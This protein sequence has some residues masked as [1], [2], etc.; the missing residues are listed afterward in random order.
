MLRRFVGVLLLLLALA[1]LAPLG[2]RAAS[3]AREATPPVVAA[4]PD[5]RF[6]E[7]GGLRI[8]YRT[9]GP[10]DGPPLLLVHGAMAWSETWRDIAEPLGAAGLR[11]IAL[12][13][14][15][16]GFSERPSDMYF[17]RAAQA[18]II[19][20]FADALRIERFALAGHSFGGGATV[21]AAFTA[22]DRVL[23]LVLLDVA[24]G[25]GRPYSGPPLAGLLASE[26]VRNAAIAMSFTNPLL[27][28]KGLRDFVHDD[29]LVTDERIALYQRPMVVRGTTRAV[30]HWF[31][32]GLFGNE[33]GSRAADLA[34]YRGFDRPVLVIWGREDTVTPLAQGQE[35]AAAFP[36]GRLEVLDG[37]NHIPHVEAPEAVAGLMAR[38]LKAPA[39]TTTTP[40]L[41]GPLTGSLR[42]AIQL[43]D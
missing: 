5:A 32:T 2:F 8:H 37:V 6:V 36:R 16:F 33:A 12:D 17:S 28:G 20:R 30:G 23:N 18:R 13:V 26:P 9:W 27:T 15:P 11:V 39:S 4:G 21:E 19:L 1:I 41:S 10:Q 29:A 43:A 42:G 40:P 14:P 25:L 3:A 7:V 35:I 31:M 34:N 22:P 38:F 24:L